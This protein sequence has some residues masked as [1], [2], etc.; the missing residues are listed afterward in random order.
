MEIKIEPQISFPV[1]FTRV[2][3]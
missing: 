3:Y 2:I 1:I